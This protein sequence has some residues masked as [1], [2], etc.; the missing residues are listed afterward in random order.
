MR[1]RSEASQDDERHVQSQGVVPL[2][3]QG[4]SRSA[5]DGLLGNAMSLNVVV[6]VLALVLPSTGFCLPGGLEDPWEQA[7]GM[8]SQGPGVD[9]RSQDSGSI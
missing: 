1:L 3:L 7:A 5:I 2:L 6:R 4:A 8:V 9:G